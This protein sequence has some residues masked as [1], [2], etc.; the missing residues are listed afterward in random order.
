MYHEDL[1]GKRMPLKFDFQERK[2]ERRKNRSRIEF[3]LQRICKK[4]GNVAL[5]T[6]K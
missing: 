1:K 2:K 6:Y 4:E 5:K 3:T